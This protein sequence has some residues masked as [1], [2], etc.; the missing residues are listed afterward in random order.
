MKKPTNEPSPAL[1]SDSNDNADTPGS[2]MPSIDMFHDALGNPSSGLELAISP[3]HRWLGSS[4]ADAPII[5]VEAS[6][7]NCAL[8]RLH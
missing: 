4:D 1:S 5:G 3:V 2:A 6:L 8:K 7:A